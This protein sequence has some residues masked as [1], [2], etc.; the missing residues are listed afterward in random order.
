LVG[1]TT[2][3]TLTNKTLSSSVIVGTLTANGTTGT[4]GQVL[5][6]TGSGVEWG[7]VTVDADPAGTAIAMAIALG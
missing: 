5:K 1:K 4:S 3:D 6:S 2:T 7:A